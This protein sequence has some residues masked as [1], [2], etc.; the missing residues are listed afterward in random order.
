MAEQLH[1]YIPRFL[2]RRFG[3]GVGIL[4]A[5]DKHTGK[6]FEISTSKKS[7]IEVA[8]E[9]GMYDFEFMG[10]PMTLEPALAK[11]EDKAA[12]VIERVVREETLD[13][14]RPEERAALAGFGMCQ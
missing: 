1:H 14:S 8:A 9:R 10:T 11:L 6:R 3:R 2:L 4:H 5:M 7:G 12:L 13:H